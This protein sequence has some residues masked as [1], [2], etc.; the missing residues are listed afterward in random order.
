M[1][2][3]ATETYIIGKQKEGGGQEKSFRSVLSLEIDS[4]GLK[5][6]S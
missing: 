3:G 1:K 4:A 6:D 2:I 5:L